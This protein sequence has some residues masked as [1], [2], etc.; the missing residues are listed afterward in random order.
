MDC[1]VENEQNGIAVH[2]EDAFSN[3]LGP[4]Q[5]EDS[6]SH[7]HHDHNVDFERRKDVNGFTNENEAEKEVS[8]FSA[9][10][11]TKYSV[12]GQ[13]KLEPD[14]EEN[15][16]GVAVSR[17][18]EFPVYRNTTTDEGD[19]RLAASSEKE[20]PAY[21]ESKMEDSDLRR[22]AEAVKA[23][24]VLYDKNHVDFRRK[25]IK[26]NCWKDISARFGKTRE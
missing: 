7:N 10:E 16:P 15:R 6:V 26:D 8:K 24:P 20:Y 5:K 3:A 18:T 12:Y 13:V 22:L 11:M 21:V 1:V 23:Y 4:D 25:D 2:K 14:L 9:E 19:T 17:T